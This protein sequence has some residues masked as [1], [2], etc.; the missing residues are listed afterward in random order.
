[1]IDTPTTEGRK[2]LRV[3]MLY[4]SYSGQTRRLLD[5]AAA[6]FA[7]RGY[8]VTNAQ[9]GFTDARYAR[10]FARFPMRNVWP[11]MLSVLPAQVA[12]KTGD[13][14]IPREVSETPYDLVCIG[15][16]T[17]WSKASMPIR[18]FLKTDE[19]RNLLAGTP[20]ATF[21]VCRDSW[22]GNLDEVRKLGQWQGGHYVGG[23]HVEY[24]GDQ[25]RSML[26]LTSFLGSGE[27]RE[28]YRGVRLPPTNVQPEHLDEVRVFAAGLAD[29]LMGEKV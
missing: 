10:R 2:S 12:G 3:L 16:P 21:V 17:W 14:S 18:S 8:D 1:M 6:E 26:S 7:T 5:T 29:R 24:P 28:S 22:K 13:I 23:M 20:F 25:L 9:I 4:Y 15:S 19:A 11:D 27:Y